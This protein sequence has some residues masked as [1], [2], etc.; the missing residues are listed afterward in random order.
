LEYERSKE[1]RVIN[2]SNVGALYRFI[3]KRFSASSGVGSLKS[4]YTGSVVTDLLSRR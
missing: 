4:Q 3:N 2:K 1:L